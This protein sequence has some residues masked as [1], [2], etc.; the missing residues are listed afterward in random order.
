MSG[1][2]VEARDQVLMTTFCPDRAMLSTFFMS[3]GSTKGPFLVERDMPSC[4]S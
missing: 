4:A 2:M 3:F 1:M